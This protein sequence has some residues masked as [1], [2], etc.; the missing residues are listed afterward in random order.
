MV[1]EVLIAQRQSLNTLAQKLQS[2]V[3]DQIAVSVIGKALRKPLRN[4]KAL[5]HVAKQERAAVRT[6]MSPVECRLYLAPAETLEFQLRCITLC[7]HKADSFSFITRLSQN[8]LCEMNR[9]LSI[10][11]VRYPG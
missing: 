1:I 6:E 8:E 2:P 7:I 10:G 3:F 4:P 11:A 9:L 5:V